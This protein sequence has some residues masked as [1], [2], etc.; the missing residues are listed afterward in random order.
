MNDLLDILRTKYPSPHWAFMREFR[1]ATGF[2]ATR[3]ADALAVG[4]YRSRG[5]SIIGFEVKVSRADWLR[6]LK[7]PEKAEPIAQF[8]DYFYLV[9]P[10]LSV[11]TV[12]EVPTPWGLILVDQV[13]SKAHF[14]KKA[15]QLQAVPVTRKFLCAIVK[16]AMDTAGM[17]GEVALREAR[18]AGAKEAEERRQRNI[19]YELD[20]LRRLKQ[21]V[22]SFTNAS[23][24]DLRSWSDGK[25]IGEAVAAVEQVLGGDFSILKHIEEIRN[26]L[27]RALQ[28]MLALSGASR[29]TAA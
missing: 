12:D 18:E 1:N 17:P 16:Q 25:R 19:P 7:H 28:E 8:C 5:Q 20:E 23:G 2:D 29:G 6:E 27:D 4:L 22:E 10:E 13:K 26:A 14:A 11:V 9:V 21:T 24:V 3:S 15:E